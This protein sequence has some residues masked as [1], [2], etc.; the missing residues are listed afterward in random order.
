MAQSLNDPIIFESIAKFG[1][2]GY[3]AFFGTL[4][5]MADEF[6]I[7][8]PGVM[9]FSWRF[10]HKNLQISRQKLTRIYTFFDEKA[11][12]NKTKDKGFLV[13]INCDGVS[14]NCKK[15]ADLCDTHTQKVLRDRLKLNQSEIEVTSQKLTTEV[16]VRSKKKEVEVRIKNKDIV[17]KKTADPRV[18]QFF[19]YYGEQFQNHFDAPPR[20]NWGKDG[21]LIKDLLAVYELEQ[22]EGYLDAFFLSDDIWIQDKGYTLGIFASQINKF[23]VGKQVGDGFVAAKMWLKMKEEQNAR[24][25]QSAISGNDDQT[26][27]Q[28]TITN[29]ANSPGGNIKD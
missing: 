6:D 29:K 21:K 11:K 2:D 7:Y 24:K 18:K 1:G 22:L 3:L 15:L 28:P 26:K 12:E 9:T 23:I 16:E 4:E 14:I 27:G 10:L 8:H 13:N 20:I 5:L 17:G 25:R 19:G